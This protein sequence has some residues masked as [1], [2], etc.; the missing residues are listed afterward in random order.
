MKG[1]DL[2]LIFEKALL[3]VSHLFGYQL[4]PLPSAA[5]EPIDI[6]GLAIRDLM[7][8]QEDIFFVEIGAHDGRTFDPISPYIRQFQ[9]R[10]L[11]IEPQPAVFARLKEHYAGAPGLIFENV[12]I[13]E[14]EGTLTLHRFKNASPED[15]ASMLAS[16]RRHYLQLNGDKVRGELEAFTV[17]ATTLD[18]LLD[19]HGIARVDLLQIDTE[20]YDF[21][22]LRSLNFARVKPSIIHFEHNFLTGPQKNECAQ[23]LGAQGYALASLGVD[24]LAYLQPPSA[25]F[26]ERL[27]YHSIIR[28]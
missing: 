1:D 16:T 20:G 26:T 14:T 15:H 23:M 12:A 5:A 2:Q 6:L 22:I 24:T 19:K 25:E 10:G 3:K 7:R 18:H 27:D 9:W 4:R 11:L 21:Q 28:G 17:P 8:R 13:A